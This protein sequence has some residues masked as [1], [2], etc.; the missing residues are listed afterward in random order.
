MFIDKLII[1]Y[2]DWK[3]NNQEPPVKRDTYR[4]SNTSLILIMTSQ[5]EGTDQLELITEYNK[6][7]ES[8]FKS[9]YNNKKFII[10]PVLNV[11]KE[12]LLE[13]LLRHKPQV[14]HFS[15]HGTK[16]GILLYGENGQPDV[17]SPEALSKLLAA[18][19]DLE[20]V[21][22]NACSTKETALA[23]SKIVPY[24]IGTDREI[25]D[26]LAIHFSTGFYKALFNGKDYEEAFEI[27]LSFVGI[28]SFVPQQLPILIK[29]GLLIDNHN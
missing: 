28:E 25:R 9:N 4:A 8:Y 21:V 26:D 23:I 15:G 12:K 7:E 6:I 24:V 17:A 20:C 11:T 10:K 27:A 3:D 18:A 16:S 29:D 22:L 19:K 13:T 14:L 1:H 5:P 2:N